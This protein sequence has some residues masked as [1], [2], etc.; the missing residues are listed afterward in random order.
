MHYV[1]LMNSMTLL[2]KTTNNRNDNIGEKNVD[3]CHLLM[4]VWVHEPNRIEGFHIGFECEGWYLCDVYAN[5]RT[6]QVASC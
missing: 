6:F 2:D 3:R 1:I 4:A 5:T